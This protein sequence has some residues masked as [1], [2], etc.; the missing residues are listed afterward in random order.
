GFFGPYIVGYIKDMTGSFNASMI[1]LAV[2][3]ALGG[4]IIGF[5][6]KASGKVVVL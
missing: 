5:L 1:F 6:I 2:V 3:L 4:I